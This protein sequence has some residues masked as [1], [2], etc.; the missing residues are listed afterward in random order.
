MARSCVEILS[1]AFSV[2]TPPL[3]ASDEVAE[4]ACSTLDTFSLATNCSKW[5]QLLRRWPRR[6]DD[7][8]S[9]CENAALARISNEQKVEYKA[10]SA[11]EGTLRSIART[12]RE[13]AHACHGDACCSHIN[14][15]ARG[16]TDS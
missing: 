4:V 15:G 1:T 11:A 8:K 16:S 5:C 12:D 6:S 7:Q 10:S 13:L 9:S 14:S 2:G 3:C